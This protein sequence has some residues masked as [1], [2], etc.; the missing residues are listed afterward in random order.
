[1]ALTH[2]LS[3][4]RAA[5]DTI[6]GAFGKIVIYKRG[7]TSIEITAVKSSHPIEVTDAA[8]RIVT[9]HRVDWLVDTVALTLGDPAEGDQVVEISGAK[10]YT[11]RVMPVASD[12]HFE[13][14]GPDGQTLRIHSKVIKTED[15][16]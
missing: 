3:V 13:P 4:I 11:Y 14:M 10:I 8:G 9:A 15:V 5:Q 16:T 12:H 2:S 1:M 7:A 6:R